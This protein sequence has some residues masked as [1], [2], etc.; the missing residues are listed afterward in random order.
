LP[1]E[2]RRP[3]DVWQSSVVLFFSHGAIEA[4][5]AEAGA[6]MVWSGAGVATDIFG[7]ESRRSVSL[8]S[9]VA[10]WRARS[11]KL[12][13]ARACMRQAMRLI[14]TTNVVVHNRESGLAFIEPVSHKR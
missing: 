10:R 2:Y 3:G 13:S 6:G 1:V 12:P 5:E 14:E 11:D 7:G 4:D 8:A 9:S